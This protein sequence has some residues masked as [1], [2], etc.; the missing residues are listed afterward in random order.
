MKYQL[1]DSQHILSRKQI[2]KLI[3][4]TDHF[5]NR[6]IIKIL[7]DTGIRREELVN[8]TVADLRLSKLMMRVIGKGN[9]ERLVPITADIRTD[10]KQQLKGRKRGFLFPARRKKRACLEMGSINRVCR[11]A[12]EIAGI[13]NPNPKL[14]NVNP[15]IF[16]HSFAH[17]CLDN[18]MDWPMLRDIMGHASITVTID[19][20]GSST[21]EGIRSKYAQIMTGSN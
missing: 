15:H 4:C 6:L 14:K 20:Y 17:H 16:R 19:I 1:K 8:I 10:I 2:K 11:E 13:S 9:K 21:V 7:A 5:R 18:G 3:D 12:G